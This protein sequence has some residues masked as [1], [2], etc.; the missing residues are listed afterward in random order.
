MTALTPRRWLIATEV[1]LDPRDELRIGQPT[2]AFE[3]E[4]GQ[5]LAVEGFAVS[6][7]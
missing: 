4:D 2:R 7:K 3:V 1:S 6:M 5:Q